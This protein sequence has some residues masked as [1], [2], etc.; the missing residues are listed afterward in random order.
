LNNYKLL[1]QYD[2]TD[3]AGWQVQ[4]NAVT[5]QGEILKGI[6][7]I[8]KADVNLIGSGRTDTGV[9][10]L[11]QT[12]NFRIEEELNLF[13][14]RHSLNAIIPDSIS[15][16]EIEKVGENFHSRFDAK[17]R[18]YLYLISN[19]KTP[20]YQKYSYNFSPINS[21]DISNLNSVSKTFTGKHDFTSMA[22]KNTEVNNKI[23][24]VYDAHWR[25]EKLLTMF[26]IE[27]DRYLHG[28]VRTI[29]G[30]ILNAAK[31]N[32]DVKYILEVLDKKDREAAGEAVP[33]Q[34]LFLFKVRY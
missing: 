11:G 19:V 27:A 15:V 23:C 25:K 16:I 26:Y 3:F 7:T 6:K 32:Y 8:L 21:Y 17:K 34:G 31:N 10:A 13:K 29:V 28:M 1:I 9:H 4:D 18:S 33:A 12:A 14:F 22:R 20:F 30:T 2:G 24:T 5:V